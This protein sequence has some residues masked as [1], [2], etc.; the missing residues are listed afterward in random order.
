MDSDTTS[1]STKFNVKPRSL[2]P[3]WKKVTL[4]PQR[5]R[6]IQEKRE[7]QNQ[8][9]LLEN[10]IKSLIEQEARAKNNIL[11]ME[12]RTKALEEIREEKLMIS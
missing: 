3:N 5:F 11:N 6:S 1:A 8:L 10:R 7:A 2:S 12:K 4:G 9:K